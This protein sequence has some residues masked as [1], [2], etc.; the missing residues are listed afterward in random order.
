M[1]TQAAIHRLNR[2]G[3]VNCPTNLSRES[4]EGVFAVKICCKK[5][6]ED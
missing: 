3:G 1:K 6:I 2:I 4:K 5:W